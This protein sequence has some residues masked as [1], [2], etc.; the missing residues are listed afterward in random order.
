MAVI[1][2]DR[3]GHKTQWLVYVAGCNSRSFYSKDMAETYEGRLQQEMANQTAGEL[4]LRIQK[5]RDHLRAQL[6]K[7]T[8]NFRKAQKE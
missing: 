3:L 5:T 1:K 2:H 8:D 6:N 4:L 7:T